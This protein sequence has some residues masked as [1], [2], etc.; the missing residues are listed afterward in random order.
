MVIFISIW[1]LDPGVVEVAPVALPDT[2]WVCGRKKPP[3]GDIVI[4]IE[5]VN[6]VYVCD[7]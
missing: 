6:S 5:S 1:K 2:L 4:I 7:T 3:E